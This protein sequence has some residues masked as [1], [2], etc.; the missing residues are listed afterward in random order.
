MD[1]WR[2]GPPGFFIVLTAHSADPIFADFA[3]FSADSA[4]KSF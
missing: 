4:V 3:G 1:A 2:L